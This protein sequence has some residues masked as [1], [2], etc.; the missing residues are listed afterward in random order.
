LE[1]S[2]ELYNELDLHDDAD[3]ARVLAGVSKGESFDFS[4]HELNREINLKYLRL[5]NRTTN[6]RSIYPSCTAVRRRRSE[7]D[8]GAL[9]L[10]K[11]QK[12]FLD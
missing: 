12:C 6:H 10:E 7:S 2:F 4:K 11:S 5:F 9:S 3:K 8:N 1:K